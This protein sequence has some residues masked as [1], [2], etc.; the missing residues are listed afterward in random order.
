MEANL[1]KP[2][3]FSP[4]SRIKFV[5]LHNK[6]FSRLSSSP[7]GSPRPEKRRFGDYAQKV[8]RT[9][10]KICHIFRSVFLRRTPPPNS[11]G[12]PVPSLFGEISSP[13]G[14]AFLRPGRFRRASR[15]ASRS[16]GRRGRIRSVPAMPI[17]RKS[18]RFRS[19]PSGAKAE[20]RGAS[21]PFP[22]VG[23][24]LSQFPRR[25]TG[26]GCRA[27][28]VP[29]RRCTGFPAFPCSS[30]CGRP[31]RGRTCPYSNP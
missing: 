16:S 5:K 11:A 4:E 10:T 20:R 30:A 27:C 22:A 2:Q 29:M 25:I 18:C 3:N 31:A 9:L 26:R 21:S 12:T 7:K 8:G 28:S 13:A 17:D 1:C 15:F 6:L 19:R 23:F 24:S 14:E